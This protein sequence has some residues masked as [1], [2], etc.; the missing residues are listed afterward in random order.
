MRIQL[1]HCLLAAAFAACTRRP[2]QDPA[3][4]NLPHVNLFVVY[5]GGSGQVR[6]TGELQYAVE[7][8]LAEKR[9]ALAGGPHDGL[10]PELQLDLVDLGIL[11]GA[12]RRAL[13]FGP[14][15]SY[16]GI[17]PEGRADV[18]DGLMGSLRGDDARMVEGVVYMRR[19]TDHD[20]VC[21]GRVRGILGYDFASPA[22]MADV[23]ATLV[24]RALST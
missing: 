23:I 14:T 18:T 17:G 2:F 4:A 13:D 6:M 20:F 5:H 3:Y 24:Q 11:P 8:A 21:I 7:L 1:W 10:A 16:S 9:I 22:K 15:D 19:S 12:E